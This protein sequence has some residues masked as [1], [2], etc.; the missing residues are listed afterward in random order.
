[1]LPLKKFGEMLTTTKEQMIEDMNELINAATLIS[2]RP[3]YLTVDEHG[4]Y[5]LQASGDIG[6]MVTV[7][8]QQLAKLKR[9][10]EQRDK[11]DRKP[12]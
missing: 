12:I 4:F 9:I 6:E 5:H 1:M 2:Q 10:K 7:V 11:I 8:E 3:N